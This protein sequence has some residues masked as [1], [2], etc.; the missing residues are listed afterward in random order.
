[1]DQKKKDQEIYTGVDKPE[2]PDLSPVEQ[3]INKAL[4]KTTGFGITQPNPTDPQNAAKGI[5]MQT[6]FADG[7]A[8]EAPNANEPEAPKG[9]SDEE[10]RKLVLKTIS[11]NRAKF[12][13]GGVVDPNAPVPV[14][15]PQE[16]KLQMILDTI[17]KGAGNLA[18]SPA[19]K[20]AGVMTD[21]LGALGKV[22]T[23]PQAQ[24][25]VGQELKGITP[26][27][28]TLA[29]SSPTAP[30]MPPPATPDATA[31]AP[32]PPAPAPAAPV[33]HAAPAAGGPDPL[34]QLG[35]FDA[36]AATPGLNPADRQAL[37]TNLNANQHTFGNYLAEA[38]AGL[39]DAVSAKGG[40]SQ[41]S[42]GNIFALQTQQRQEALDNFDKARQAAVDHFTMKNQA[43][44][45]LINNLKARGELSISPSI[46][47]ALGHPEL[48][49][50]PVAQADL[51][52]KTDA[53]KYDFANKMQ[54]R[55][56]AALKNSADELDKAIAH[57]G[58]LGTQKSVDPQSRLRMIHAQ[59]IK[60]D[61]E[62][63]GY[64]IQETK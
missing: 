47:N 16:S 34:A 2:A 12:D 39:G 52:L 5:F 13:D 6:R 42:L 35:K 7:G 9:P 53:M 58:I 40:V 3:V 31:S 11:E 64:S 32:V 27:V 61:P 19:A 57:G 38:I 46:A 48:A 43:D 41:N 1:M 36:N 15:A 44:Q 62:A 28:Q 4:N 50:K 29:G 26:A 24:N 45:N 49:N 54:E 55:K 56:Q 8:V 18:D 22:I 51:V 10:K 20:I 25:V 60:N 37:A 21:P 30:I 33:T 17:R 14:D 63:F 59:A 23:S